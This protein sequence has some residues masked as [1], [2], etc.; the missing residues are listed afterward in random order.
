MTTNEKE[1]IL[2]RSKARLVA[3]V[4]GIVGAALMAVSVTGTAAAAPP[5]P[6]AD[7]HGPVTPYV[8]G[9]R[10][11]TQVYSFM[12]SLQLPD[13]RPF[14]GGSLIARS[15][16]V[17]AEHCMSRVVPGETRVR[18]GS[19]DRTAGGS[20]VGVKRV[21]S[22]PQF[23]P[24]KPGYDVALIELDQAVPQRP[25]PIAPWAGGVGTDT[26]IIGWG[27]TCDRDLVTDPVCRQA[28]KMLQELDT[29]IV[30][31]ERCSPFDP[32]RELCTAARDG[33]ARMG[34]FG[35]SGGPQVRKMFGRWWLIGAT[36]GDGD[37]T[38]MRPHVCT[39]RPDGKP[40]TGIWQ[41]LPTYRPWIVQT[42]RGCDRAAA[43]EVEANSVAAVSDAE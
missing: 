20:F 16:V 42:L 34:C 2:T 31:D 43:A 19:V 4:T 5:P 38:E 14:C 11:A 26:R 36:T 37:D 40:G 41:D 18:I 32:R 27:V 22:H 28:P 9:G 8:V 33:Q 13:G 24:A 12:A 6:P 23:D 17:S 39:T 35:D 15:W 10:D 3:R 1:S 25:I 30:A 7:E 29:S 21:V